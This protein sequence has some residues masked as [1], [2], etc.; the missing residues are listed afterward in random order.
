MKWLKWFGMVIVCAMS[1][2]W[3]FVNINLNWNRSIGEVVDEYHGVK[4]YYN[5]G[6]NHVEER[7][8]TDDGYNLGLKYQCVEFVKRFYFEYYDHR[9]PD[10]YGHA[11]TFFDTSLHDGELNSARNLLQYSNGSTTKPAEG[12]ILVFDGYIL[13]RFGH[14]AIVSKCGEDEIEMIQQNPGPFQSSRE[15]YKL[16]CDGK[17]FLIDHPRLLGWLHKP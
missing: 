4:V 7:N 6:V 12:D 9:M 5:G 11:K 8:V 14:V 10:A 17:K 13:N 16:K 3:C 1:G 2:Y 15:Q